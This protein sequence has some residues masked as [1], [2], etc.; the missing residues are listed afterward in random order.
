MTFVLFVEASVY[1]DVEDVCIA[2]YTHKEFHERFKWDRWIDKVYGDNPFSF[3]DMWRLLYLCHKTRSIPLHLYLEQNLH[4]HDYPAAMTKCA[5]VACLSFTRKF[6]LEHMNNSELDEVVKMITAVDCHRQYYMRNY[7]FHVEW[8]SPLIRVICGYLAE[9]DDAA[10]VR[11]AEVFKFG[12]FSWN[13]VVDQMLWYDAYTTQEAR[14]FFGWIKRQELEI[15][16][17]PFATTTKRTKRKYKALDEVLG[18]YILRCSC[19]A[20]SAFDPLW[21]ACHISLP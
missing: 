1:M 2:L 16:A 17:S 18:H 20:W 6:Q 21:E 10:I 7:F 3:G 14:E 9:G 13:C 15:H 11:M 5:K 4:D 8:Y 12:R 19:G